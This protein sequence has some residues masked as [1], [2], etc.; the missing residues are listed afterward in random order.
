MQQ[1]VAMSMMYAV[2]LA[3]SLSSLDHYSGVSGFYAARRNLNDHA[4]SGRCAR[5]CG[6][7]RTPITRT[8][9]SSSTLCNGDAV[10]LWNANGP[11]KGEW[12]S[13]LPLPENAPRDD[14][15]LADRA[16][17]AMAGVRPTAL[18]GRCVVDLGRFGDRARWLHVDPPVVVID[19]FLSDRECDDVLELQGVSPPTGAG[20]VIR[21][22]SRLS[23]A[24][25]SRSAS[26]A[27]RSSTTWYARYGAPAVA[28]LIRGLLAL[29]PHVA[30]EQLEEVHLVRYE[31]GGQGFGWHEDVLSVDEATPAAGGQRVATCLV[32]LNECEGGR[33]LFRDLRGEDGRRLGV[34]PEKGRALLFFPS[35]TG[36]SALGRGASMTDSPRTTFGKAYFD[37]TRAD[38]RTS[39]A[40]EPPGNDGQKNIAQ[41]WIHSREHTPRVFGGGLN[42]HE[43]ASL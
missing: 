9:R 24:N 39:H 33:T 25:R 15:F 41:L 36:T 34:S 21:I 6:R 31:G 18:E 16:R 2:L 42:K 38:H 12:S 19:N 26:T 4:G 11:M 14:P 37:D 17:S 43:E 3:L 30:L 32:Y 35:V 23:D 5:G 22:E 7:L 28:P 40:G 29:L 27:V 10:D 13:S 1:M 8:R 20:R